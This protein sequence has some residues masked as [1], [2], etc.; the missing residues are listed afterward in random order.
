MIIRGP[1]IR[2]GDVCDAVVTSTDFYPTM[3]AL[4][5][6]PPRP[7]QHVD[8]VSLLPLLRESGTALARPAIFW[9]YP[10]YHGSMWTPGAAVR[11]GDWKLVEFYEE[12][13]V[14]LYNLRDDI[15]ETHDL[16]QAKPEKAR[17]LLELL[18][19]WQKEV[20]AKMPQPN[21]A[22]RGHRQ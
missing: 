5:G 17:Q 14:E 20:G 3:L 9:H 19:H 15:G 21:P 1:G 4:A 18:H 8:G 13:R 12:G 7:T 22:Y 6:L 2:S 16:A 10:H 11:A